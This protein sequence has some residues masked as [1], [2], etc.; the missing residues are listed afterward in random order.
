MADF[1]LLFPRRMG[2]STQGPAIGHHP[3]SSDQEIGL[4]TAGFWKMAFRQR[5]TWTILPQ[6]YSMSQAKR[7]M[8]ISAERKLKRAG[9]RTL[10]LPMT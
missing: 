7:L 8:K 5:A 10:Q 2:K 9:L 6:E 1:R 3:P 4:L